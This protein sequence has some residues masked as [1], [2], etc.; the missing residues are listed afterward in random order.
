MSSEILAK[1]QSIKS[2]DHIAATNSQLSF[3]SASSQIRSHEFPAKLRNQ[4]P[5]TEFNHP[6][7]R[8][9]N[10]MRETQDAI[11]PLN[12]PHTNVTASLRYCNISALL[13]ACLL[14]GLTIEN[15]SNS[16]YPTTC[17]TR[18][19]GCLFSAD[20]DIPASQIEN[21][22]LKCSDD[23]YLS[24]DHLSENN[25]SHHFLAYRLLLFV[26]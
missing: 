15:R 25:G 4:Q 14:S 5:D 12:F 6:L 17:G 13:R 8:S 26:L 22:G 3:S 1:I 16:I 19:P 23:I 10:A 24:F 20:E 2:R 9:R 18:A 11:V 7:A 21:S